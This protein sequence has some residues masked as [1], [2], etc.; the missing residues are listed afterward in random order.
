MTRAIQEYRIQGLKTNLRLFG[1][2]LCDQEWM[3]G[4]L[5]TGFIDRFLARRQAAEI[6]KPPLSDA[7]ATAAALAHTFS[8]QAD[9]AD[10]ARESG[11][12][13]KVAGRLDLLRN[14]P[15]RRSWRRG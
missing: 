4:R 7:L 12:A 2:L 11:N 6:P 5:S 3:E 13:W 15:V 14:A 8:A 10:V 1:D 9:K